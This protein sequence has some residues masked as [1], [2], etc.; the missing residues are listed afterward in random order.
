MVCSIYKKATGVMFLFCGEIPKRTISCCH[1]CWFIQENIDLVRCFRL[2][3]ISDIVQSFSG[4]DLLSFPIF[5]CMIFHSLI[6]L[7]NGLV[8]LTILVSIDTSAADSPMFDT[9]PGRESGP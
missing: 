9:A 2:F 1:S 3:F 7:V 5:L 4:K 8:K 6:A